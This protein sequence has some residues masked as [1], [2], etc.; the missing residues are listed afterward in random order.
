M[1]KS[2]IKKVNIMLV[3]AGLIMSFAG[4]DM[5]DKKPLVRVPAD[6]YAENTYPMSYVQRGDLTYDIDEELQLDNYKEERYGLSEKKI[7]AT[8]LE[9]V[10]FDKLYVKVGDNVK[11]GDLLLKLKSQSLED[12]INQ[13][14][15]QREVAEIE[16]RHLRNRENLNPEEDHSSEINKY[17]ED[18]AI[19][20]GYIT[21]LEDKRES[22]CIR[23]KEDGKVVAVSDR[24]ISGAVAGSDDFLTVASGDDTYF[25][26]TSES[27][28]LKEGDVV[29][30]TNIILDYDVK[31][32]KI[33]RSAKGSKIYFKIVNSD[34]DMTIVRG[35][36]AP[37]AQETRKDVLYVSKDCIKEKNE[38]YYAFMIDENGARIAKEVKID[39]I[40]GDNVIILEGLNEGDE[41]IA[42]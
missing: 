10:E 24:A 4:C 3:S 6:I 39:G 34:E 12:S 9:D 21:E 25:A 31:V 18:I 17:E 7:S 26:E 36:V 33:E 22:L 2:I 8:M 28:T 32:T 27:T 15:E 41:I 20:N 29:T 5:R 35:L 42:K 1:K 13:Y 19:A 11:E 38:H 23:A 14:I 37:V 40:V 16:I 30:A